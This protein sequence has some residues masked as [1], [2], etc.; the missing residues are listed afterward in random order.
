M[1][2]VVREK[3]DKGLVIGLRP[4]SVVRDVFDNSIYLL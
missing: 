2:R 1:E 4:A 3:V